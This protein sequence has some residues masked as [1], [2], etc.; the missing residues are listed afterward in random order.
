MSATHQN[1]IL[2][3]LQVAAVDHKP[4]VLIGLWSPSPIGQ[5]EEMSERIKNH[6]N[7]VQNLLVVRA[8]TLLLLHVHIIPMFVFPNSYPMNPTH[9]ALT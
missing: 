4:N 8:A 3:G 7:K 6:S 1:P 9:L 2:S 5:P